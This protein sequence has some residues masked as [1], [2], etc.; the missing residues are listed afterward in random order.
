LS[1]HPG[2]DS[3]LT[4]EDIDKLDY[5]KDKK[6][7]ELIEQQRDTRSFLNNNKY[8]KASGI[9]LGAAGLAA[10][11]ANLYAIYKQ[12]LPTSSACLAS[13]AALCGINH[14]R[15]SSIRNKRDAADEILEYLASRERSKLRS[16]S[17]SIVIKEESEGKL[18]D[19]AEKY[20]KPVLVMAKHIKRNPDKFND[21]WQKRATFALNASKWKH[22]K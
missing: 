21:K 1:V 9:A 17:Y 4:D 16:K 11:G 20:N 5:S 14:L 15:T 12:K 2:T 18:R 8:R 13:S 7:K 22:N 3:I 6:L 10:T 19:L